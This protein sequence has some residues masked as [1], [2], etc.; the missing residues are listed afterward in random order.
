MTRPN[1]APEPLLSV[2][3]LETRF[4]TKSGVVN[5]VNGISF[6]LAPG[7]RMAIVGES[8]SGKSVMAMSLLRLVTHP[9]R[10]VGGTVML[11]GRDVLAMSVPEL[12]DTRGKDIAMIFQDPLTAL[13]P[14]LRVGDQL[15]APL[16]RHLGLTAG[17]ARDRAVE[18][19]EQV[20]IPDPKARLQSYPHELSGGMRQRVMIA[21]ALS[22]KPSLIIADEPTTALDVTIQAQVINLLKRLAEETGA[23]VLLV[24]HDLG[25]VARFA[26]K[27]A[28]MYGGR[29]V[30]YGAVRDIYRDPQHPYTRGL[31]RSLPPLTG[32]KLA[33]LMQIDG[34]PPDMK[35]LGEGCPFEPRCADATS[36]CVVER[37]PLTPRAAGHV[38]ACWV[39]EDLTVPRGDLVASRS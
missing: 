19:L 38:A 5:A 8:G 31:L 7:E 34:S 36:R 15:T 28:V 9:G 22:C 16:R 4:F 6:D 12:N 24:T 29:F 18:L 10:I 20:G 32:P 2:S 35:A 1:L 27:V 26:Q 39:T 37:P 33:R 21:M 17:E 25:L 3:D 30:E 11:S 13:N 23:A 14:V